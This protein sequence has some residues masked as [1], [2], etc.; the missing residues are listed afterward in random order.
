MTTTALARAWEVARPLLREA[1][2][3]RPQPILDTKI[4]ASWNGLMIQAFAK[5]AL[6]LGEEDA[7]ARARRAA[8][9]VLQ[10]MRDPAG[11]LARTHDGARARHAGTLDDYAFVIAGL[12]D[13]YEAT[14]EVVWL[15]EAG[16]LDAVLHAHFEDDV[17]GF[18]TTADDGEA[19]LTREKP[20]HDGAEPSGNSV[21]AHNLFRMALLLG[22][23]AYRAR[24][25]R[26][27]AAFAAVLER[28]P[29]ALAEM[30][31]AIELARSEVREVV[32]VRNDDVDS[33]DV[34][35]NDVDSNDVDS[36]AAL[37]AALR[38]TF[39]PSRVVVRARSSDVARDS[40]IVPLLQGRA[41][42]RPTA[43]VCL[44]GTCLLP[45]TDAL[46]FARALTS[47]EPRAKG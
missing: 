5:A 39:L 13:L 26:T 1:R 2:A 33:N 8:S 47:S 28:H 35:S 29:A 30:L 42:A 45:S 14:G 6:V 37:M 4:I 46:A 44:R 19:L 18:F 40:A 38:A 32:V 25:E 36:D 10:R 16:A 11:R 24:G 22:D 27:L 17:G 15:T 41:V 12:L 20:A 7:A 31:I 21:H 34:D 9:F 43:W 23:D 3:L